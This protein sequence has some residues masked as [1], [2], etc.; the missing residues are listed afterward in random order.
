L[1][2]K[3]PGGRPKSD[4]TKRFLAKVKVMENGCHEWQASLNR[5]GYGKFNSYG[6]RNS[7]PAHRVA[8]RLFVAPVPAGVHVLHHC[9]NRKCVNVDHL[10]LGS[11]IDNVADMDAKGR[12]GT[13][14][15]LTYKDVDTIREML[16]NRYSQKVIAKKFMVHQTTISRIE[17][18]KTYIFK[19][20]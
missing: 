18:H 3:M 13:K 16:A 1:E 5:G 4:E 9:D 19:E 8:Y 12:R 14:S 17:R 7:D 10:F 6:G 20:N 15:K 11:T 2:K